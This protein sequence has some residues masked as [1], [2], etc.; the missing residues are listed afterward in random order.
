MQEHK[1]VDGVADFL[2]HMQWAYAGAAIGAGISAI[3]AGLGIGK[4]SAAANESIARQPEAAGNIRGSTLLTAAFIEGVCL[5]SCVVSF[6]AVGA[7]T[8]AL[9]HVLNVPK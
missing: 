8:K 9:H 7:L 6:Q 2:S 1:A 4:I 3:A 5:F